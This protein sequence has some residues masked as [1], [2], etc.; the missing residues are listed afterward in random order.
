MAGKVNIASKFIWI[1]LTNL[2][3]CQTPINKAI[4]TTIYWD[5]L[6]AYDSARW[7]ESLMDKV[8]ISNKEQ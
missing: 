3:P 4:A 2:R 5:Q 8:I 7:P 6:A 1:L